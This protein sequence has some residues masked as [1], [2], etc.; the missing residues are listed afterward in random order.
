M[1]TAVTAR[2]RSS[3]P[4]NSETWVNTTSFSTEKPGNSESPEARAGAFATG[5]FV[6]EGIHR[7]PLQR[8][9]ERL[10]HRVDVPPRRNR[11][12]GIES[13]HSIGFA[14]A[15]WSTSLCSSGF[16]SM[17][18]IYNRLGAPDYA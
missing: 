4:K 3:E 17:S 2:V 5:E 14:V 13:I 18:R 6:D 12:I 8:T 11:A 15:R 9:R 1:R 16:R 7:L 10:L